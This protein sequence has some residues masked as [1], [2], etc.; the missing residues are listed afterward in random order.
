M[1]MHWTEFDWIGTGFNWIRLDSTQS[2]RFK[3]ILLKCTGL[4]W[5][6]LVRIEPDSTGF[7][8]IQLNWT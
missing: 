3:W 5:I 8:W 6:G 7:D 1:E 2:I 4:D